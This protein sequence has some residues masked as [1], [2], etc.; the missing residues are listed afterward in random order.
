MISKII[1]F[2]K[3]SV[4]LFDVAKALKY[5]SPPIYAIIVFT[6]SKF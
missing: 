6:W 1:S 3:I 2:K 5:S 4:V